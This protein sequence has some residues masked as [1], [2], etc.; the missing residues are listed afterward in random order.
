METQ[1]KLAVACWNLSCCALLRRATDVCVHLTT[2]DVTLA[3]HVLLPVHTCECVLLLRSGPVI[4]SPVHGHHLF[5][6]SAAKSTNDYAFL[7]KRSLRF[8]HVADVFCRVVTVVCRKGRAVWKYY[9][10]SSH[11]CYGLHWSTSIVCKQMEHVIES[12]LR[13]IL[14]KKDWLF[15]GN[16]YSGRNVHA[17]V[18]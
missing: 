16:T 17:K 1:R 11:C 5:P 15:K 13:K 10:I 8:S 3:A 12:D 9:T 7:E 6:S 4:M 18:K 14:D 2:W